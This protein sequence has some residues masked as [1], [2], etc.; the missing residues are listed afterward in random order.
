[1]RRGKPCCSNS[2]TSCRI[3]VSE[4]RGKHF[5]RYAIFGAFCF[6]AGCMSASLNRYMFISLLIGNHSSGGEDMPGSHMLSK[7]NM[8]YCRGMH[9]FECTRAM[10]EE[11]YRNIAIW[12]AF[13]SIRAQV[14][15]GCQECQ[16]R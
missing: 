3:N 9:C 8:Q 14:S 1:M 7:P 5:M 10:L 13:W 6:V 4:R 2:S 11:R 16:A 12:L 15:C